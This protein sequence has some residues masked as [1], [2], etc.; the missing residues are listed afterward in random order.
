M[1]H[2]PLILDL[3]GIFGQLPDDGI[4]NAG[5]TSN[6]T[7]TVNGKG[8]VF[9]DGTSTGGGSAMTLQKIYDISPIDFD[10]DDDPDT[11]NGEVWITLAEGK[12]LV[13]RDPDDG[14]FMKLS[15]SDGKV[16][17]V[18]ELEVTGTT[19]TINTNEVESDHWVLSPSAAST[20]A[21]SVRPDLGVTPLVDLVRVYKT[22]AGTPVV[23]IDKDGNLVLTQNIVTSGL[24]DGV[25]VSVLNTTVST[26]Q[27]ASGAKHAAANISIT[28]IEDLP[29]HT[30][31]QQALDTLAAAMNPGGGAN[32][33]GHSHTQV[34]ADDTWTIV[35]N[36]NTL[37][38]TVTIFDDDEE[39]V[40]PNSVQIINV[41]TVEVTFG[42]P[43]SGRAVVILF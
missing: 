11:L 9:D 28:A 27:N 41:N 35:H 37:N 3:D 38:V 20:I 39:Q 34:S 2:K 6:P 15:G 21:L 19:T 24:V 1:S 7:F 5:G 12:D 23:R 40:I 17:I 13:I 36:G 42:S 43:M 22:F 29:G 4:I 10:P 31:V 26:H 30:T 14:T 18:G 33:F 32:A 16:T 25:D 8:L